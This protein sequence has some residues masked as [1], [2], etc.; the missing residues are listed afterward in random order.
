QRN[1]KRRLEHGVWAPLW[2]MYPAAEVPV[3]E[4]SLPSQLPPARLYALG[5][6]LGELAACQILFLGSGGIVHN[7]TRVDFADRHRAPDPWAAEFDQWV[8][9]RMQAR[10]DQQIIAY[11]AEAPHASLAV[12]PGRVEHF[13]PL[14]VVLGAAS[15]RRDVQSIYDGFD[16]ANLSMRCFAC[17]V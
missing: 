10:D 6:T 15:L 5:Q 9:Q 1:T 4:I 17:L 12:P 13:A 14:W 8:W 16:F 7:L 3:V 2:L 11:A